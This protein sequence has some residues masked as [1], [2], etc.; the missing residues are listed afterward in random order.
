MPDTTHAEV[1][2]MNGVLQIRCPELIIPDFPQELLAEAE[3]RDIGVL[4]RF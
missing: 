4:P 1:L 2:H 3:R